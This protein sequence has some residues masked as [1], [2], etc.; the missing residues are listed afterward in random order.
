MLILH[1]D[2]TITHRRCKVEENAVQVPKGFKGIGKKD[3]APKLAAGR[4]VFP[5]RKT[6]IWQ[7]LGII[8]TKR[9]ALAIEGT[10]FC[11][12]FDEKSGVL[13]DHWNFKEA[14]KFISKL[15]S[16]AA[17]KTKPF[18]TWQV[19]LLFGGLMGVM[20]IQF[21]IARRLGLF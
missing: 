19:L 8:R 20:V 10:P 7:K 16:Q 1:H 17:A 6:T 11:F 14:K 9:Y 13:D 18:T 5:Q 21:F 4:S 12:D 15:I 2:N 3:W